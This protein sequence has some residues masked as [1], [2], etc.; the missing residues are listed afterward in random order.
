[1][2]S[3]INAAINLQLL[4]TVEWVGDLSPSG[5]ANTSGHS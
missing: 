4:R 5:R 1:M 2:L 3:R